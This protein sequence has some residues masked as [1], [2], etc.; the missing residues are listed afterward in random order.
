MLC[1]ARTAVRC[2]MRAGRGAPGGRVRDCRRAGRNRRGQGRVT[3]CRRQAPAR[4]PRA[5]KDLSDSST[6]DDRESVICRAGEVLLVGI[7][8]WRH[9]EALAGRGSRAPEAGVVDAATIC[10]SGRACHDGAKMITADRGA[11]A[12][13]CM[14][15]QE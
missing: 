6:A 12:S 14:P 2:P 13:E 1:E 11:A 5:G 4:V 10:R 15:E 9:E 7:W 8:L 3:S